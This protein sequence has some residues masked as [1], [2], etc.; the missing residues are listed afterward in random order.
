[1]PRKKKTPARSR[2]RSLPIRHDELANHID[3]AL[4]RDLD[5]RALW[6][7][8][9]VQRYAKLRGWRETKNFPWPDA[10]NAHIPFLMTEVLRTQDTMHNAVLAR[11]PV[12][13]AMAV[14]PVNMTKQ[15]AIDNLIDYQ[16]FSEQPGEETVATLIQQY[17]QDG[18]FMA[19]VPWIRYDES[20]NDIRIFA[21]IPPEFSIADGVRFALDQIFTVLDAAQIDDDG[22]RWEI[23]I[24]EHGVTRDV[25]VEAYIQ[26]DGGRLELSLFRKTRAYDGPLVIPKSIDEWVVPWRCANPQPPSPSN[27]NGAEHV[28]L[29]DYPTLD[30][31]KRLAADGYYDL[32][33]DDDLTQL[34]GAVSEDPDQQEQNQEFKVIK[35]ELEGIHGGQG[36]DR[37]DEAM[38]AGKLTR[39]MAFLGWDANGDGLEEQLVVW[40]IRETKTILR[41]RYLTEDHPSDPPLRPL[42]SEGFLPIEGRMYA[43]SLP[44]VLESLQDLM[45]MT[46]DQ[47]FDSAT[48]SNLPWFAYRPQSGLNPETFHVSPG[49][50]MPVND[51]DHDLKIMNFN[52]QSDSYGMNMLSL[53]TQY[54]EKASMQGDIQFGR[55]PKGKASAL[56]TASG[57]QSILAQGDARPERIMRRFFSGFKDIYRI[58]HELNQRFLPPRKQY[59]LME[60]DLTG[61]SVY[62]QVD[63]I[64]HISGRMQFMFKAGMFNSDKETAQQ[65]LQSLMQVLINP[66]FLQMGI[67]GPEQ[68]M[69]LLTDFI[70][71]VQREPTR[72][73]AA[74]QPG[75][76]TLKITAEEAVSLILSGRLPQGTTPAEGHQEHLRKLQTFLQQPEAEMLDKFVQGILQAYLANLRREMQQQQQQQ[77]LLQAAQQFQQQLGGGNGTPGPQAQGP[78]PNQGVSGNAPVGPNELLD[79]SLPSARGPQ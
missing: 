34:E 62:A 61:Q 38:G 36:M 46:F 37:P 1:M 33:T 30:E 54:A 74:P 32:V 43:M 13:E 77:Q 68:I 69:N 63:K 56:R 79:E 47:M 2:K 50:G 66:L 51:P 76:P 40:M 15:K 57:M 45:K 42:A 6:Q 23:A 67:V 60:P 72:Y 14:Q 35:D 21:P 41:A 22:F 18:V 24:D 16:L 3:T 28:L 44:E 26:E 52:T 17:V 10:S 8:D 75:P 7:D 31:I 53:L 70:K 25:K 58:V 29:L 27:P 78:A 39:I 9:R 64:E 73:L 65:V 55:V 12:C 19:Y 71:L 4:T 11:H 48:I 20:V 59:R 5:D 49:V